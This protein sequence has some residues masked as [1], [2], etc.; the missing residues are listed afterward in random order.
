MFF[1]WDINA[2]AVMKGL[3]Q[4]YITIIV[5]LKI[6][7]TVHLHKIYSLFNKLSPRISNVPNGPSAKFSVENGMYKFFF[8]INLVNNI[9]I[10]VFLSYNKKLCAFLIHFLL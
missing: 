8:N 3:R 2:L 6:S 7:I 10:I 4:I 1:W 9:S 5:I